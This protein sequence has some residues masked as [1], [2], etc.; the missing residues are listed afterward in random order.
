MLDASGWMHTGDLAVIDAEGYCN[1]VGRIKDMVIRGGENLYPREIEEFLYRHPKIQDVQIFGVADDRYGEEL[2][3]WVRHAR[4]RDLDRRGDPRLLPGPDRPQQDPALRRI[5][6]RVSDDGD[7]QDPE[8]HHARC[9]R[10]AAR[11]EGGEDGVRAG[12]RAMKD[13]PPCAAAPLPLAGE[14]DA[15]SAAGGGARHTAHASG[16]APPPQPSP[17]SGRGSAAALR[18]DRDCFDGAPHEATQNV[19]NNPMQS[20]PQSPARCALAQD[21]TRRANHGHCFVIA[22]SV[23]RAPRPAMASSSVMRD[24]L[25]QRL[26]LDD[27]RGGVRELAGLRPAS[28]QR[29]GN[30]VPPPTMSCPAS[31]GASS[32]PRP[33]DLIIAVPAYWIARFRGR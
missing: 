24:V 19:E 18:R 9:G 21:L 28:L 8:I 1:I 3:A 5:R 12:A 22:Q 7:R 14:V 10:G 27:V 4:R 32:T 2:C 6:R 26:G 20:S 30:G 25:A 33:V 11:I 15:Q 17:A 16:R 29:L 13:V 23:R 31:S